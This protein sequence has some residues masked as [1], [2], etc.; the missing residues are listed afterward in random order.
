MATHKDKNDSNIVQ[1]ID[2][3]EGDMDDGTA[4]ETEE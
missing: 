3:I 2:D 1:I 4:G